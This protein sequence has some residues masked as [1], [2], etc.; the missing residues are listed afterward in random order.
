VFAVVRHPDVEGLGMIT[1][2]T[3][4]AH[5]IKGWYRIS[6]WRERPGDLYLPDFADVFDDLDAPSPQ[7]ESS[8]SPAE[9]EKVEESA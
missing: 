7:S 9:P 6:E 1:H 5:Q 8:K 2:G 3:L 4:E